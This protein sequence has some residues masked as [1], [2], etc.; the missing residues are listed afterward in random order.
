MLVINDL[1][2]LENTDDNSL[3]LGGV[4]PPNFTYSAVTSGAITS[5]NTTPA[6]VAVFGVLQNSFTIT[7]T[8]ADP[9]ITTT[10]FAGVQTFNF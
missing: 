4:F 10:S 6:T 5:A 7:G 3:V 9:T 1:Q 8:P 2:F